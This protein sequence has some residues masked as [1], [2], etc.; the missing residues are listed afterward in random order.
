MEFLKKD[1]FNSYAVSPDGD[2]ITGRVLA[3]F[4][5]TG[6]AGGNFRI[7][8]AASKPVS[9]CFPGASLFVQP[10]LA[11]F[12]F[13][14]EIE[15]EDLYFP[16]NLLST[17]WEDLSVAVAEKRVRVFNPAEP[18]HDDASFRSLLHSFKDEA[19]ACFR[20]SI[21]THDDLSFSLDLQGLPMSAAAASS[22]Q[23]L[24]L[25]TAPTIR[26]ASHRVLF[27]EF[28]ANLHLPGPAP[29]VFSDDPER[30]KTLLTHQS[31]LLRHEVARLGWHLTTREYVSLQ[32]ARSFS[33]SPREGRF[34]R[35]ICSA[36]D[37][38][39]TPSTSQEFHSTPTP[40]DPAAGRNSGSE[41]IN[42]SRKYSEHV[43]PLFQSAIR[44]ALS[45][46]LSCSPDSF[47]LCQAESQLAHS[48]SASTWKRHISAWNSFHSFLSASN[49][50][51]SWPLS[52]PIIRQYTVWA[53]SSRHLHPHTI[54]AYLSSINQI[55][56]LLGFPNLHARADFLIQSLLKGS[57]HSRFY[58]PTPFSSRRT[59]SFSILKLLGHQIA[60]SRWSFDSQLTVWTVALT[61]F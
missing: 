27:P 40:S 25:D 28:P 15:P 17:A 1:S 44:S 3:T 46:Q 31:P 32:T 55:H 11:C 13:I 42:P 54:E 51:L 38:H 16:H 39:P 20:W 53:H 9:F 21:C 49:L 57:E 37:R 47:I 2:H 35:P 22:K 18:H 14:I 23:A 48:V 5:A 7:V 6:V 19:H 41:K 30:S 29:V 59:V 33:S 26:L 12:E 60:S 50:T 61:A 58:E 8:C 4:D 36:V 34:S 52:L 45:Y 43:P 10:Q 24:N 56:Q